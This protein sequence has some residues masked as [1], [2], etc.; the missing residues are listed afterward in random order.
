MILFLFHYVCSFVLFLGINIA[1]YINYILKINIFLKEIRF[2]YTRDSHWR[3]RVL[4]M[5]SQ[6]GDF[7]A[8]QW[9]RLCAPNA[10]GMGS[11]PGWGAKTLHATWHGQKKKKKKVKRY[12]LQVI[13]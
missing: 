9:L 3:K 8:V 6:K 12:K 4:D 13:R 11:I 1:L 10:E 7:L 2:V 5:D